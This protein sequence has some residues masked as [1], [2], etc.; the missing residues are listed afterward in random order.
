MRDQH[1]WS[2]TSPA[3]FG[4]RRRSVGDP[5]L[6]A[7]D[8][9]IGAEVEGASGRREIREAAGGRENSCTGC[10]ERTSLR[11]LLGQPEYLH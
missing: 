11:P 2:A 7:A 4:A 3:H 5:A 8:A 10:S 1:I 9:H 6:R